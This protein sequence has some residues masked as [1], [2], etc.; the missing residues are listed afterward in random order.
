MPCTSSGPLTEFLKSA[1][2]IADTAGAVARTAGKGVAQI[3]RGIWGAAGHLAPS[4]LARAG[5]LG[6]T[7]LGAGSQIPQLAGRVAQG[8]QF[9]RGELP[10]PPRGF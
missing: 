1:G 5:L 10:S 7:A 4:P 9:V 8:S 6:V 3:G 2:L